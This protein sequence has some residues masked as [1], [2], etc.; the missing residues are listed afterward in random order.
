MFN[1]VNKKIFIIEIKQNEIVL[2]SVFFGRFITLTTIVN[3]HNIYLYCISWYKIIIYYYEVFFY[4]QFSQNTKI[5]GTS[6]S[7]TRKK[8]I[9]SGNKHQTIMQ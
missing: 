5:V 6:F 8:N 7:A 2:N 1:D 9:K 3:D 4:L